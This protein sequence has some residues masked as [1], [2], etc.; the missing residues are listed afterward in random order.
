M[1][2]EP[3]SHHGR[4]PPCAVALVDAGVARV[5]V[6]LADPDPR[7]RAQ[8]VAQLRAAASPSSVGIGADAAARVARPVPRSTA[9]PAAPPVV[10]TATSLDGRIAAADGSSQWITG[11]AAR[12]DAH[13]LRADSQAV[14]VGAG[15]ALADRPRS[16][17]ATSTPPVARQPLRVLLDATGRVAGRRARCSTPRSRPRWW[18]PPTPPPDGAHGVAGRRGQ[19]ATSP[20][21]RERHGVDLDATL[22]VLGGQGVLQALVEGG[23]ALSGALV[24]AGLADRLVTY[25]APTMLG[26]AG[27]PR[28]TSPAPHAS[29]TRRAGGWSTSLAS[30]PT[31]ASTTSR[32][33]PRRAASVAERR[34]RRLM[35]TGI[36][37]EL[38]AVRAVTPNAG[39]ARIEIA[40]TTVLDDAM[41][42][43]SIAVNGCCLTVVEL[44]DDCWAADAVIETLDRTTLGEPARRAT[45]STSSARCASP[46]GWAA[47]SCRATSTR[48]GTVRDRAPLPDGSTRMPSPR[49]PR[50]CATS[51]RRARSPST[52]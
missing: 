13:A 20:P 9:A 15:T 32:P 28:S 24:E 31:S 49:P 14:V 40:A 26:R 47:T 25:V 6:A 29:P 8:G 50:C 46:T 36:V 16:P 35:F 48:S 3:C 34:R 51:S 27:G 41:L 23:A 11:A 42:G 12:A 7:S 30:A 33:L 18:S 39:G 22:A 52:A 1:T 44:G 38:G 43:A 19:G 21:A 37:E 5:V 45:R 17:P 4:T 10:K 2:L